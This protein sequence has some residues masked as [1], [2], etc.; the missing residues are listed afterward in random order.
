MSLRI[1]HLSKLYGKNI[2]LSDVSIEIGDGEFLCILGPSGC[3]KTTLLRLAGGFETPSSGSILLNDT[4]YSSPEQCLPV[5]RRNLGMVFQSFALWPNMTV[6][7]HAE[8]PL[9]RKKYARMDAAEKNRLIDQALESVGLSTLSD[10]YPDEL[11]GGQK[12]RVALARAIITRPKILLM[13]EPLSALDAE[14]KIS[15]RKEIQDIHRMTGAT[16]LYVT[17]DQNEALAMADRMMIMKNGRVEQI[18]TPEEIY[19]HPRTAFTAT[20]V[21]KYNLLRGIWDRD[22]F[23]EESSNA[24]FH[25]RTTCSELKEQNLFPVRPDQFRIVKQGDGI[26][27]KITNRQYCGREIHYSVDCSGRPV[28]VYAPVRED[29]DLNDTVVLIK[30]EETD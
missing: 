27:G 26:E 5:E 3:G 25:D 16:I 14:L 24:C 23:Y 4:L 12:Q 30:K 18:G 8:F 22:K 9:L 28:T 17:H 13:D 29:Y 1:T 10:R 19:L 15:M 7:Q 20:F 11:S 2:A 6:R 21:G